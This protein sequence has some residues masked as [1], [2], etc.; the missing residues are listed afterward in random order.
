LPLSHKANALRPE[1]LLSALAHA[2][3]ETVRLGN[4]LQ[5]LG[6]AVLVGSVGIS[7]ALARR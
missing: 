4:L 1:D 3:K 6:C 7:A 2:G 5:Q